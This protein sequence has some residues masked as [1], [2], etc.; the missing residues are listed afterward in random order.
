MLL[1]NNVGGQQYGKKVKK[2]LLIIK[3]CRQYLEVTVY[4]LTELTRA[5]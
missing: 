2:I 1:F 5:R 3:D 4:W